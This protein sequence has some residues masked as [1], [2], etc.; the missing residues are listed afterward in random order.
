MSY[1]ATVV[2]QPLQALLNL[3]GDVAVQEQFASVLT[4]ALPQRPNTV[5][6]A[7]DVDVLWLGPN[8]WLVKASLVDELRL[9]QHLLAAVQ[10][11]H[12]AVTVVSDHYVIFRLSGEQAPVILQQ[13]SS[14]D[15]HP[16]VFGV[17]QCV[18]CGFARTRA[19][20][21]VV[22]AVPSYDVLAEATYEHYL[23]Q[24]FAEILRS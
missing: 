5:V 9:H 20:V 12:A 16:R 17:G 13:A 19:L 6:S 3:R 2:R 21:Q 10:D 11:Q 1:E 7:G 15:C 24:W 22:D 14:I 4:M 8:E 23:E 18:R